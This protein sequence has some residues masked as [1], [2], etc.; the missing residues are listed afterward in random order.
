MPSGGLKYSGGV[1]F[2]EPLILLETGVEFLVPISDVDRSRIIDRALETALR[3][4]N[5]GSAALIGEINKAT[6]DF[7][8]M[9]HGAVKGP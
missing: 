4:K 3:S 2:G 7:V 1:F 6:R 8:P 5:Y 9:L